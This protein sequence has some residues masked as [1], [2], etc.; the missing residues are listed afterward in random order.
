MGTAT[1]V[2]LCVSSSYGIL[3][4]M[5]TMR[6]VKAKNLT[7]YSKGAQVVLAPFAIATAIATD[8]SIA[9]CLIFVLNR[10]RTG[11]SKTNRLINTLIFY[12]IQVGA[13]TIVADAACIALV[14]QI[15]YPFSSPL[16]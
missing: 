1:F 5:L 3:G 14:R 10:S 4:R 13:I 2:N 16:S 11:F 8:V 6:S 9:C 15:A 7:D 12:A